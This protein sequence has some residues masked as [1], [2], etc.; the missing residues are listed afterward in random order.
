MQA[1][2][3]AVLNKKELEGKNR[4]YRIFLKHKAST[5]TTAM[6]GKRFK[7]KRPVTKI[8]PIAKMVMAYV[9]CK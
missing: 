2:T 4:A 9:A 3:S 5:I 8:R 7:P 1:V 6:R